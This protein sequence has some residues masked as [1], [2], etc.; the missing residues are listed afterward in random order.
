[1]TFTQPAAGM[2]MSVFDRRMVLKLLGVGAGAAAFSGS[3]M[4]QVAAPRPSS[5]PA[6]IGAAGLRRQIAAYVAAARFEDLPPAAVEK[7]KEQIVFFFGRAFA[8]GST[9]R[10]QHALDFARQ[11]GRPIAPGADA[12]IIGDRLRLAPADAALVNAMLFSESLPLRARLNDA[13]HP[14]VV[15][16]PAALAIGEIMHV[17]GR[18][19][20]LALVVGYEVLGKLT[21]AAPAICRSTNILAGYAT[22]AAAGRLFAL[23]SD[24]IFDTLGH[25]SSPCIDAEAHAGIELYPGV[26]ARNGMLAAQLAQA[27][28]PASTHD[29]ELPDAI[30]ELGYWEILTTLQRPSHTSGYDS[31]AVELLAD[32]METHQLDASSIAA[33]EVYL[34]A[35]GSRA[36]DMELAARGPYK[37]ACLACSAVPYSLA[38]VLADGRIDT[39]R[40][41]DEQ[42]AN[43]PVVEH[44]IQAID[45]SFERGRAERWARITVHTRDG[46]KLDRERD[47]FTCE[48]TPDTWHDWLR[49][50]GKSQFAAGQLL[51]LTR[52]IR[53]LETVE[54]VS[55][56]LMAATPS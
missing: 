55:Q 17:S 2:R 19:L 18:E 32:L 53:N 4:P 31:A 34:P 29:V 46:R 56:L 37:S 45:V 50:G 35:S 41:A 36:R 24:R 47:F 27:G 20:L 26:I 3:A 7:A 10:A 30:E 23:D 16:L 14:G 21:E 49:T 5:T 8:S 25:V 54:D 42:L 13:I 44:L 33:I 28:A 12:S 1:M 15:T 52:V 40:L 11:I 6:T 48:L 9:A 38:R 22:A 43:D 39:A 51:A